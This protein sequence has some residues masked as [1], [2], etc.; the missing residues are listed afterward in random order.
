M[1]AKIE[2]LLTVEDLDACPDDG[3]RYELIEGAL[4]VSRSPGIPHQ[5][6]LHDLQVEFGI[7]LRGYP[8]GI[9]LPGPGAV[10]ANTT[11]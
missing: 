1:A 6:V 3:N 7:Y 4:F 5:R 9:L 8:I 11:W 10:S 2:P